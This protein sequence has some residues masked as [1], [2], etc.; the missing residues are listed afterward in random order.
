MH[1]LLF[2]EKSLSKGKK[3]NSIILAISL[4]IEEHIDADK[5]S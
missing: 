4:T 3:E 2:Q 5:K 1:T